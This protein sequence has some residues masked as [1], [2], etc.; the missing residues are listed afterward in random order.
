MSLPYYQMYPKDFENDAEV[1][2]LNSSERGLYFWCL[3]RSWM[4]DGLPETP[5]KISLLLP[6]AML[7]S[8]YSDWP[9]IEKFFPW[10]TDKRRRSN[11]QEVERAKA[12]Q[13]SN[14]NRTNGLK[15]GVRLARVGDG[16]E[17]NGSLRASDISPLISV[18]VS[19][20]KEGCGG[21]T[22]HWSADDHYEPFVAAYREARFG[23]LD[24]E[25]ASAFFAWNRLAPDQRQKATD[26]V[27]QRLIH[28]HWDPGEPQFIMAP[29]KYLQNEW[30]RDIKPP[31]KRTPV[32]EM[33]YAEKVAKGLA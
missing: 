32:I 1:L 26:G 24:T 14:I 17:A 23:T 20:K 13:K 33:S 9:S 4:D 8:F 5:A 16:R 22:L 2:P 3:N 31:V 25:F 29:A 30:R 19:E 10:A 15:G 27:R 6:A 18:S 7:G 21:K 12:K 11:R 28:G